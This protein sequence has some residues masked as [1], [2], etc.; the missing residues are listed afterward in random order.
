MGLL[1]PGC[2]SWSEHT[3]I[4]SGMQNA[5]II[6]RKPFQALLCERP[7][8]RKNGFCN[9]ALQ[10]PALMVFLLDR[11]M[12]DLTVSSGVLYETYRNS[13]WRQY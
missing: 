3:T 4:L 6:H 9:T 7:N 8:D 10:N 12:I 5:F 1:R 2:K 11:W 13:V